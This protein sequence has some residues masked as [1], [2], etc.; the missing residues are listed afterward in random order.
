MILRK[1][2]AYVTAILLIAAAVTV[3][4]WAQDVSSGDWKARF[5]SDGNSHTIFYLE[6]RM[7]DRRQTHTWG[8]THKL[9]DFAGLDPSLASK[10][11][12]AQFE[13]RREAGTMTFEGS[14]HSGQG[15]G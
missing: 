12:P 1:I 6:M 13:L 7:S 10:D 8:D 9:S 3:H 11:G 5:D 4:G 2:S 14:F 15:A